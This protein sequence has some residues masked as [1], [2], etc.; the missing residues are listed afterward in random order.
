MR[1]CM[2]LFDPQRIGG[3]E[4][5]STL[6]AIA[7]QDLGEQISV[8]FITWVPPE[9][10]YLK[11]LKDAGITVFQPPPLISRLACDWPTKER[12]VSGI[13]YLITPLVLIFATG[14]VVVEKRCWNQA[15]MS[16]FN[17]LRSQ[18]QT[19]FITPDRRPIVGRWILNRTRRSW[20]PDIL[21]IHGYVDTLLFAIDWAYEN[22]MPI[23]Y[24]EHQTPD[25]RFDWWKK[26]PDSIN[27]AD[28]V[29]AVSEASAEALRT[30]CKVQ[31]PMTVIGP[32]IP[33]PLMAGWIDEP[34]N[35][36]NETTVRIS[37]ISR[38]TELKGINYLLEAIP[39]VQLKYP[40]TRFRIYGEG[41]LREE[42]TAHA[43][44]LGLDGDE[45]FAGAFTT[46]EGLAQIMTETDVFVMPSLLEGQPLV[47]VEA[48]AFAKPILVT[49]VGGIP[50][51]IESG[52]NGIL[53]EPGDVS[54]LVKGL[55]ILIGDP[56]LRA[57]LGAEA[58]LSYQNGPFEVTRA[59]KRIISVYYDS[60][61]EDIRDL[62]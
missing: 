44:R 46:R 35:S 60:L 23:V 26:T 56:V 61:G 41:P 36:I 5:Y 9:N 8:L 55:I 7:L 58:R 13:M 22:S 37:T 31:R 2:V 59:A 39:Q 21:H 25:D 38:L 54:A 3:I 16:A 57:R 43:A 18:L 19:R 4:E 14:L 47:L 50:E 6:L 11:R 17:W 15:R 10:Q 1:I 34:T 45:L 42:L 51:I 52:R 53:V 24:Q 33:D 32:L 30:V 28:A 40:Q 29:I 27:K 12:I 62:V 20:C 48:M 49:S